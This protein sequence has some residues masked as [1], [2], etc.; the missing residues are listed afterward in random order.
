MA[1]VRLA[2]AG[3]LPWEDEG[4]KTLFSLRLPAVSASHRSWTV[5]APL[6]YRQQPAPS[7]YPCT[8]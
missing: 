4:I 5:H 6:S 2:V 7:S 3:V 1:G 8:V